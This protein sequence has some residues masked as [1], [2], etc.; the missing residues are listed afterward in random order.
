[1]T[2]KIMQQAAD[3]AVSD[4]LKAAAD[5]IRADRKVPDLA[6][7]DAIGDSAW[8]REYC[9]ICLQAPIA[10]SFLGCILFG[11]QL[12]EEFKRT[13]EKVYLA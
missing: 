4:R 3:N 5:A 13:E 8:F 10:N 1:M 2:K 11:W 9:A 7:C 6:I 12:C